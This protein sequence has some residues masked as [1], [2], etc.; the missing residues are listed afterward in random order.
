MRA[1]FWGSA[2]TSQSSPQTG[3]SRSGGVGTIWGGGVCVGT[4]WKFLWGRSCVHQ[5]LHEVVPTTCGGSTFEVPT[6]R[7]IRPGL[8]N[9]EQPDFGIERKLLY[10][11]QMTFYCKGKKVNTFWLVVE[12][13]V[14]PV[15]P[16]WAIQGGSLPCWGPRWLARVHKGRTPA[17]SK[18]CQLSLEESP[19]KAGGWVCGCAFFRGT[20]PKMVVFLAV[21]F[22]AWCVQKRT[23]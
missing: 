3:P 7:H 18:L 14:Q 20:P 15:I 1:S 4:S 19:N 9:R 10:L 17:T 11:G 5:P 23:P 13:E 22:S 8:P 16:K 21:S 6:L 12:S 2:S